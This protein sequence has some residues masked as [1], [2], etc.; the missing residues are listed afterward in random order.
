MK[1][2]GAEGGEATSPAVEWLGRSLSP[3]E[4]AEL[5]ELTCDWLWET[6]EHHRY[7]WLSDSFDVHSHGYRDK[8][9]GRSR[10]EFIA[11]TLHSSQTAEEHREILA[12]R[13]PFRG[14]TF[15]VR[16]ER[17]HTRWVTVSGVPRFDSEGRFIGY[18]GIGRDVSRPLEI[19]DE[20]VETRK[21]FR[22]KAAWQGWP[23]T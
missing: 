10:L 2:G 4:A 5:A 14:L 17:E 3:R 21:S 13:K 1:S 9:I 19:I 11:E 7:S 18:R 22:T 16:S 12:A 23:T 6:D 8:M 15:K 20:L